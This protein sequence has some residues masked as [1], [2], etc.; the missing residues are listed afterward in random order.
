M[1][2]SNYQ[3]DSVIKIYVKNMKIRVGQTKENPEE[4]DCDYQLDIS[5]EGIKKMI[6]ER[7]GKQMAEKL[8]K[9]D[10]VEG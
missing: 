7:M 8:K 4:N 9:N 6:Y 1:P 3:V 5:K 2:I 10:H